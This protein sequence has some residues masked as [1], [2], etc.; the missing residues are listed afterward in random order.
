MLPQT[1][2]NARETQHDLNRL[3][4]AIA[5]LSRA[6]R[7]EIM[8]GGDK[9][10]PGVEVEYES[11]PEAIA[12]E[13]ESTRSLEGAQRL[14]QL[15]GFDPKK[16]MASE[17][18]Q[19]SGLDYVEGEVISEPSGLPGDSSSLRRLSSVDEAKV[20]PGL[21]AESAQHPSG[22][23]LDDS[24]NDPSILSVQTSDLERLEPE[25]TDPRIDI[26]I[27]DVQLSGTVSEISQQV[28]NLTAEQ[29][30]SLK[31]AIAQPSGA[32]QEGEAISIA[33]NGATVLE[34]DGEGQMQVNE[35]QSQLDLRPLEASE[36]D[37]LQS[38]QSVEQNGLEPDYASPAQGSIS[39]AD[40][41]PTLEPSEPDIQAAALEQVETPTAA[42]EIESDIAPDSIAATE[43]ALEQDNDDAEKADGIEA[44]GVEAVSPSAE[45]SEDLAEGESNLPELEGEDLA[46]ASAMELREVEVS[47]VEYDAA[48]E[49]Q[50]RLEAL[51]VGEI[52]GLTGVQLGD[53]D[54][55]DGAVSAQAPLA[56]VMVDAAGRVTAT[57]DLC[58][59]V[60][61]TEDKV[62]TAQV[63][64][65]RA[66]Q[67]ESQEQRLTPEA[68]AVIGQLKAYFQ[69]TGNT[70]LAGQDY[71]F[72]DQPDGMT[73]RPNDGQQSPISI[74][75]DQVQPAADPAQFGQ[76]M[77]RFSRTF[78][79][80]QVAPGQ[81]SYECTP[82]LER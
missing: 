27:G 62:E 6:G 63:A 56:V 44:A 11:S 5:A 18:L 1:E 33:V 57:G 79:R 40:N 76:L 42:A 39:Q 24:T 31:Q 9:K 78:E 36:P 23:T 34:R 48:L 25:E 71:T 52:A 13:S 17:S 10:P 14:P 74:V 41:S 55:L 81:G 67:A 16:L 53:S 51:P 35:I 66:E 50:P 4:E 32:V 19:L 29:Q 68:V 22:L 49:E 64:V 61:A 30:D 3:L 46:A 65:E 15:E 21:D 60:E 77:E 54:S 45:P 80:V 73:I 8:F 72:C 69:E 2:Q 70:E 7:L 28:G 75:G 58:G 82:E 20:E 12:V 26:K 47:A 38:A 43:T 37:R 59:Q